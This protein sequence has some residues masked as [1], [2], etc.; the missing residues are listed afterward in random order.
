MIKREARKAA[1]QKQISHSD[2]RFEG[3][4]CSRQESGKARKRL[5]FIRPA[6]GEDKNKKEAILW[7]G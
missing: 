7:D 1:Y 5:I 4:V 2:C 3:V 6:M